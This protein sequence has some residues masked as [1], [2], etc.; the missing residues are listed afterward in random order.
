[1]ILR[2][3]IPY[4]FVFVGAFGGRGEGGNVDNS[5]MYDTM[6]LNP[7]SFSKISPPFGTRLPQDLP[8]L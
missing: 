5:I 8:S 6:T 1:M 2:F 3:L 7:Y 4:E